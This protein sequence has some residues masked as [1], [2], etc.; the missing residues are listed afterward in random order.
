[1]QTKYK[2]SDY[3]RVKCIKENKIYVFNINEHPNYSE[4]FALIHCYRVQGNQ[5]I[6][7]SKKIEIYGKDLVS[8]HDDE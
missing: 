2:E 8:M 1:M 3:L 7:F 6:D 4:D 5:E